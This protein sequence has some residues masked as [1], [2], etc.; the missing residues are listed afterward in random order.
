MRSCLLFSCVLS[1]ASCVPTITPAA[2]GSISDEVATVSIQPLKLCTYY[3]CALP[4]GAPEIWEPCT[5]NDC[6]CRLPDDSVFTAVLCNGA[7]PCMAECALEATDQ[8]PGNP[9]TY[10]LGDPSGLGS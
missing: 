1:I 7:S 4:S 2:T 6:W 5:N 8:P 10:P 9:P 3:G